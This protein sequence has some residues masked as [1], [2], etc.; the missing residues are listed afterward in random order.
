[1]TQLSC[2]QGTGLEPAENIDG[3]GSVP[4]TEEQTDVLK[5]ERLNSPP[6]LY[7][8]VRAELGLEPRLIQVQSAPRGAV[9]QVG[10]G[11]PW[12]RWSSVKPPVLTE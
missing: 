4:R 2:M 12:K 8:K 10:L 11:T 9:F 3:S 5:M 6:Q 7:V 1:M